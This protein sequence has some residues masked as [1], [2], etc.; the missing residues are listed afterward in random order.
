MVAPSKAARLPPRDRP[1][2][3]RRARQVR[4]GGRDTGIGSVCSA[5]ESVRIPPERRWS[6]H[7][8]VRDPWLVG[9][10]RPLGSQRL[11]PAVRRQR[12]DRDPAMLGAPMHHAWRQEI[13]QGTLLG[14]RLDIASP[15]VDGRKPIWPGSLAVGNAAEG[16]QAVRT[17]TGERRLHQGIQPPAPGRVFR[18]RGRDEQAGDPLCRACPAFGLGRGSLGGGTKQ[19]RAFHRRPR[20][21]FHPRRRVRKAREDA[22]TKLPGATLPTARAPA[23]SPA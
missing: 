1:R 16:Q 18:D 2:Y 3:D 10:A 13:E 5:S 20:G 14:P 22:W 17:E 7:R 6:T 23:R 21:V 11:P 9:H 15:I 8:Q 19:H 4:Y 12:G